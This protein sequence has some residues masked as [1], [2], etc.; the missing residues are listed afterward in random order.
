MSEKLDP[1]Q[2]IGSLNG[3]RHLLNSN[4]DWGQDIFLLEKWCKNRPDVKNIKVALWTG[5]PLDLTTIP[6][7]SEPSLYP[8]PGWCAISVNR[9]YGDSGKYRYYK[10][11][12][13]EAI[14]GYTIYIYHLTEEDITQ[15]GFPLPEPEL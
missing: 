12:Y 9:L 15:A 4:V 1:R 14:I 2:N 3:P 10:N 5:F 8:I 6:T 13:P 11:F 7:N